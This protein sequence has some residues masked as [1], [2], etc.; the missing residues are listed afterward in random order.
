MKTPKII[1]GISAAVI[2]LAACNNVDFK[3]TKAGVAYK[4]FPGSSKDSIKVNSIVKYH[5][6][7]TLQRPGKSDTVIS[8]SYEEMPRFQQV[9]PVDVPSYFAAF[10]E[11]VLS[12]HPGDSIY[13]EQA[14]D[15][16]I[17][18]FPMIEQTTTFRNGDVIKQSVKILQVFNSPQEA[19]QEY[20][21]EKAANYDKLEARDLARFREDADAK[22]QM[23]IDEQIIEQYLKANNI[24]TVRS[25]WGAYVQ[26]LNE[27]SGPKPSFGKY[28]TV[29]YTGKLLSGE[30]FDSGSFP[31]QFGY[32]GV[33]RGFEEGVRFLGTGGKAVVYIPSLLGYGPQGSPPKIQPNQV[34]V[35]DL[36]VLEIAD[37]PTINL[38]S[39]PDTGSHEGHNH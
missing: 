1:L 19:E 26:V 5:M 13:F 11:I 33:V 18:K 25:P 27:G 38:Q 36:E 2:A 15:S 9:K 32:T 30:V 16:F 4:I 14:M 6:I 3:K 35:F 34:L 28:V 7:Q 31:M 22:Q 29:K 17:A 12:A 8:N 39:A 10:D 21:K 20:N 23:A 37:Q 24:Q